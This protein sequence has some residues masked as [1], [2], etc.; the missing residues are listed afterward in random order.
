M[1]RHRLQSAL[2]ADFEA[3]ERTQRR[4][5]AKTDLSF[6]EWCRTHIQI[7][8]KDF[9]LDGHEYLEEPMS[10]EHPN[11]CAEKAAQVG[12]STFCLL[13]AFYLCERHQAKAVYYL[14]TDDDAD[15]FSQDR[16][17]VAIDDS[18]HLQALVEERKR[19]RDNVGLRHVGRGSL[20]VR[21]MYT[22]RKVKSV[23][24]D[25][26]Y[27]D[28]LDE[29]DQEN[30]EFAYDRLLHSQLQY[31]RE[32][33]QPSIP[34]YGI[35]ASFQQSDMRY[36]QH[37]CPSCGAW[38]SLS[39]E[40]TEDA[41]RLLPKHFLEIPNALKNSH[42]VKPGQR[43]Y[44]ACLAC[45]S[46]LDMRQAQW[47]A[48][49]PERTERMGWQISQLYRQQPMAGYADPADYIM[50]KLLSARN[51][52]EKK[53]VT[54]SLIGVPYGGDTQPVTD[55]VLDGCEGEEGFV[56][57]AQGC[58]LGADQGDDL[59]LVVG[60]PTPKGDLQ[61]I[62]LEHTDNWRRIPALI[63]RFGVVC[64]VGDAMPNKKAMKDLAREAPRSCR[65]WIQYFSDSP[66]KE[67]EEGEGAQAVRKV[68]VDR[69]E[70]LDET[71][72]MLKLRECVLPSM[73]VLRGD[74]LRLYELFRF[75]CKKLVKDLVE[76]ARG[77]MKWQYKR[78][79]ANHFGMAFNSCRIAQ[80]LYR[81]TA[82]DY[83]ALGTSGVKSTAAQL[84]A[85]TEPA[86]SS[87]RLHREEADDDWG[88]SRKTTGL[89]QEFSY[90]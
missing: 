79:V 88:L 72:D 52:R 29:A 34:D 64:A 38:N 17:N 86:S 39:E 40:L 10:I 49:H 87:L 13:E 6:L 85:Q 77:V 25:I 58:F 57:R 50:D 90:R 69:T 35:D 20:Y 24:A 4:R 27:L 60:R 12:W 61:V 75:Q 81:G 37:K 32:L 63:E 1:D 23:D 28:E 59:H 45:H 7:R 18:E 15:D 89:L 11:K 82:I 30:R 53:R 84:M 68:T 44:R 26:I 43:Y 3:Q 73:R 55:A 33:S 31:S 51:T 74:S 76:G 71:V 19:G 46:P 5:S 78:N 22:K 41:G 2:E 21:G 56:A 9:S 8:G 42:W 36:Y 47:V 80:D 70:S 62:Y 14:S 83:D 66:L 67:G 16:V 54:I 65:F 48:K